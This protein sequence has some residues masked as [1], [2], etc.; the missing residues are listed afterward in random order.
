MLLIYCPEKKIRNSES[1]E[2]LGYT[3]VSASKWLFKSLFLTCD[4]YCSVCLAE[5]GLQ[6][7]LSA[8][9]LPG[10]Y[11]HSTLQ[12]PGLMLFSGSSQLFNL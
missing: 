5:V 8:G 4:L 3:N 11:C 9:I 10:L 2:G 1:L 6:S 7:A 12:A